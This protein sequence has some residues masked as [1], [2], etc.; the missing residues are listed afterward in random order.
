MPASDVRLYMG[1]E[2]LGFIVDAIN[3]ACFPV[4]LKQT[5]YKMLLDRLNQ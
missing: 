2:E 4:P 3:Y 5:V 1:G